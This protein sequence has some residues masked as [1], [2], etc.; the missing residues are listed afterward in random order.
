MLLLFGNIEQSSLSV[1]GCYQTDHGFMLGRKICL[2]DKKYHCL[3]PSK[4]GSIKTYQDEPESSK[5][6]L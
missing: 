1:I 5:A 4:P 2:N 3:L 6:P